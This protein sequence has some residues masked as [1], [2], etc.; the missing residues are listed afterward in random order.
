MWIKDKQ[1]LNKDFRDSEKLIYFD[2]QILIISF[3]L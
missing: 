3:I 1:A 2:I